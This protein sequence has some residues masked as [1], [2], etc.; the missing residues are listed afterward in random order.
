MW[1]SVCDNKEFCLNSLKRPA[2]RQQNNWTII[3]FN[4]FIADPVNALR[5]AI[6]V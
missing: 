1:K 5:C 6:Q 4:P 3:Y 2:T